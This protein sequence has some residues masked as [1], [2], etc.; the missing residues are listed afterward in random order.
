M[1][2][3]AS[4]L[5]LGAELRSLRIVFYLR[6][7]KTRADKIR[8]L[9]KTLKLPEPEGLHWMSASFLAPKPSGLVV[10]LHIDSLNDEEGEDP[11]T[12]SFWLELFVRRRPS[13]KPPA[14]VSTR[15]DSKWLMQEL[16]DLAMKDSNFLGFF[17]V[18]V[19]IPPDARV[20]PASGAAVPLAPLAIGSRTLP[21]VGVEYGG[22]PED[23][24]VDSLRWT[25][26]SR[27]LRVRLSYSRGMDVAELPEIWDSERTRIGTY[28]QEALTR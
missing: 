19:R 28:V 25:R 8:K 20:Q 12:R 18:D 23:G 27:G 5:P 1:N 16:S 4:Q 17:E 26:D 13:G 10:A 11:P 2:D 3:Q 14:A 24:T 15:P 6:R 21:V 22:E 7:T 9:V